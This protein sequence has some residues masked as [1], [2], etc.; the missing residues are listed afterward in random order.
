M[1][2]NL[3]RMLSA[4]LAIAMIAG[5]AMPAFAA[6]TINGNTWYG[7]QVS[8]DVT[9]GT[10]GYNYMAL[11]RKYV[12]GYEFGG[13]FMGDGEGPQTFVVIDTAKYDGK[14]WTPSGLY[15]PSPDSDTNYEVLYCCD[16]ETMINDGTYYKRVNLDDSEYYTREQANKIRAIVSNS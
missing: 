16:V 3:K 1:A 15:D 9:A 8:V 10:E 5:L 12:H 13:H 2:K 4:V 6:E 7:D 14:T 11:F